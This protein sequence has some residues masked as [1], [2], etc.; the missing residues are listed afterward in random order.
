[1]LKQLLMGCGNSRKR[2]IAPNQKET[3][4]QLTTLDCDPNCKPDVLWDLD[5]RPLPFDENTF[6]EVH[7]YEVL[8]HIG[9]QGDWKS[10][11]EEFSE[12]WRIIKPNGYLVGS[13]PAKNSVWLWG[14]PGHTREISE[15][16][17]V[18]LDQ[19]QYTKQ[20]GK[21]A[22]TDYRFVY[23]ADFNVAYSDINADTFYFALQVV[24]PSRIV[25]DNV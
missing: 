6:D 10:F 16:S 3:W 17:F 4:E 8:E 13:C 23:K 7:A 11:F 12:Y 22:M 18:F 1:M 21:T 19:S 5:K 25:I 20:I 24:K 2:I 14:D 15:E 9:K